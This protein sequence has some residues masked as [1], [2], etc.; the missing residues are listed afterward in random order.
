MAKEQFNMIA[1]IKLANEIKRIHLTVR[2]K[3]FAD[4]LAM[5]WKDKDAWQVLGLYDANLLEAENWKRMKKLMQDNSFFLRYQPTP[6][7]LQDPNA[8]IKA[9]KKKEKKKENNDE[10]DISDEDMSELLSKDRQL[11]DLLKKLKK[12]NLDDNT[13]IKVRQM[14]ADLTN[15]KKEKTQAEVELVHYFLPAQSKCRTCSLFVSAMGDTN[16]Q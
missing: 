2:E 7:V 14:I 16:E 12:G 15:A 9:T 11:K 13:E 6:A 3:A 1:S 10:D 8:L 4:L 5:G